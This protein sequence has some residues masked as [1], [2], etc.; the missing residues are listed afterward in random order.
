VFK[1]RQLW[2]SAL[3]AGDDV[4]VESRNQGQVLCK[5]LSRTPSGRIN[6]DWFGSTV[7][8]DEMG[9]ERERGDNRW[10]YKRLIEP[11]PEVMAKVKELSERRATMRII[12]NARWDTLPVES[13]KAVARIIK[14]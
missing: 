13:L 11:T 5:V 10:A 8:F 4:V 14:P 6:I 7:V 12:D 1:E 2:I 3:K 9:S